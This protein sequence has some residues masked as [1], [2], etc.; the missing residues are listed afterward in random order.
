MFK[1][2]DRQGNSVEPFEYLPITEKEVYTLG[3]ALKMGAKATKC[4]ATEKP[5]HICMGPAN[6]MTVPAIPVKAT[7]RFEVPYTAAPAVGAAVTLHTDGLQ[8]TATTASGVFT[9]TDVDT[10]KGTA[11]GYFR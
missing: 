8:V 9:V 4:G 7:T 11:C 1:V 6:G 5:T 10:E 3:E 2:K